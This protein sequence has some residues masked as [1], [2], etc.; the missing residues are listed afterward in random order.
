MSKKNTINKIYNGGDLT[1]IRNRLDMRQKLGQGKPIILRPKNTVPLKSDNSPIN[2]LKSR[3]PGPEKT[4]SSDNTLMNFT[5]NKLTKMQTNFP[6]QQTPKKNPLL[7]NPTTR[8]RQS[9]SITQPPSP[10]PNAIS[11]GTQMIRHN[12]PTKPTTVSKP[13]T[14]AKPTITI[15]PTRV[16]QPTSPKPNTMS[17]PTTPSKSQN[18]KY[19]NIPSIKSMPSYGSIDILNDLTQPTPKSPS[20][21]TTIPK[22]PST[23]PLTTT[24]TPS[25]TSNTRS[26]TEPTTIRK[27]TE[28]TNVTSGLNM[29][30][31]K[32]FS[33]PSALRV[34]SNQNNSNTNIG[35]DGRKTTLNHIK[36]VAKNAFNKFASLFIDPPQS[37]GKKTF[38]NRNGGK[39]HGGGK[40][41]RRRTY[42]RR[43]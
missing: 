14:V 39:K 3:T 11:T 29:N 43:K 17:K 42:R 37:G 30:F 19:T 22:S 26:L 24:T 2:S 28:S 35:N 32:I 21:T 7:A 34:P 5:P 10:T 15:R 9:P 13:T 23:S 27:D 40:K 12:T 8:F 38:K 36:D 25:N 20:T 18:S 41:R 16:S 6:M 4:I 31:G 33:T 1:Q